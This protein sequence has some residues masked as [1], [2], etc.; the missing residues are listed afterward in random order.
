MYKIGD[1]SKIVDLPV[2][3]IRYYAEVGVLEPTYT[4]EFTGYN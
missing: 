4:D 2:R 3:T 1:F